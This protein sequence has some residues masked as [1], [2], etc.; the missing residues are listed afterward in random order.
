MSTDAGDWHLAQANLMSARGTLDSDV[1]AGFVA[2][3]DP[4]NTLADQTPGFVWRMNPNDDTAAVEGAFGKN[5]L[6]NM[7]VWRSLTDLQQFVYASRHLDAMRRRREWSLPINEPHQVL[8]WMPAGSRPTVADAA[9]RLH[10][11]RAEGPNAGAFTFRESFPSPPRNRESE[12]G[13]QAVRD[14]TAWWGPTAGFRGGRPPRTQPL[15]L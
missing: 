7:S 9:D 15:A 14:G 6:L 10:L 12:R 1:M 2:L 4:V 3:L 11:L 8:W 5:I 13:T